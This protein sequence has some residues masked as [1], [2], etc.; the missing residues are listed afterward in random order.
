[1]IHKLTLLFCLIVISAGSLLASPADT[2]YKVLND[3][4][5]LN[6]RIRAYSKNLKTIECSFVQMKYMSVLTQ[7]SKSNGYFCFK[8][9]GMVRWEYDD[10]FK[11]LVIISN[12]R[13]YM[14]DDN[15]TKSYDM[16]S[17]KAFVVLTSNLG[18]LLQ[19]SVF[20]NKSDF[21]CSY[22]ENDAS[23]KLV[24]I[25]KVKALKSFFSSIN[26]F[27]DKKLFSVSRIVMNEI[28]GDKTIIDFTDR[29]INEGVADSKF[30]KPN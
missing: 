19:G 21:T 3:T 23:Y 14:K 22:Y 18:K 16:T 2:T 15:K 17:S 26:L 30:T 27:F 4:A 6:T 1:M 9:P 28:K 25:P 5:T 7:P 29:K 11:Y 10:P 8:N 20:D 13:I 12:N 24:L